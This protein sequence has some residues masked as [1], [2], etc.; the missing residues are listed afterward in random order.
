MVVYI[1][2]S[3]LIYDFCGLGVKKNIY[4]SWSQ[5]DPDLDRDFDSHE[6]KYE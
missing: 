6:F 2:K 1:I 5:F 4:E 3:L